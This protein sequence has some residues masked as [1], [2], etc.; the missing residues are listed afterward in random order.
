MKRFAVIAMCLC[1]ATSA[2]AQK[3]IKI[4]SKGEQQAVQA[5]QTAQ[6][7]GNPDA[8]I[9][10][11]EQLLAAYADTEFKVTCLENTA[12]S[13]Q[14]KGDSLKATFYAEQ[15]LEADPHNFQADTL[16][17]NTYANSTK[18]NDLDKEEK[19]KKAEKYAHDALTELAASVKPNP[20][21]SDEQWNK[22]KGGETAQAHQAHGTAMLDRKKYN[23]AFAEYKL[24][25]DADP[26]DGLIMIRAGR[27]LIS[28][29]KPADA[30]EWFDKAMAIPN[31]NPQVKNIATADKTRASAMIKK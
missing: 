23:E 18:E 14:Q 7:T 21:L 27:A 25:S 5:V 22:I 24:G 4:K 1:A 16:L 31:V 9:Q 28:A 12:E 20:T 6:G 2:F 29:Q 17:A 15:T 3:T 19:L 10:A 13:Y 11:C 8:V 26:N 30:I